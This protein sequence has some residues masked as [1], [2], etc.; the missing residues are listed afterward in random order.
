MKEARAGVAHHRQFPE[1]LTAPTSPRLAFN[2]KSVAGVSSFGA[3]AFRPANGVGPWRCK[4]SGAQ[5]NSTH[6]LAHPMPE[7]EVH[8]TRWVGG[9]GRTIL[10]SWGRRS[11]RIRVRDGFA[12]QPFAVGRSDAGP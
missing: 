5:G 2:A 3:W 6:P 7:D 12:V 11:R 9:T 1:T 4:D 10:A 8:P